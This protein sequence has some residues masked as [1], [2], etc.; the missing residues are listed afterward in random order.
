MENS[1]RFFENRDCQYFPCH[2]K[3][4]D[5]NC[6]FCYCPLYMKEHCPGAPEYLEREGGRLKVC[7]NCTFPHQPEN[8]DKI[9]QIL[10]Q[11]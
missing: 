9:M 8:Y 6:L 2:K 1:Y 5:F 11:K 3:D 7:T 10:K 4:G